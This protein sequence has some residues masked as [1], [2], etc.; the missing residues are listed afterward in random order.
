MKRTSLERLRLMKSEKTP[1][2]CLT[3]YDFSF[4][5]L[6]DGA[7]VDVVLVGDSLGMVV[8]G[9]STTLPVTLDDIIY[10]TSCVARGC[11][12]SLVVA[13]M[14]FGSYESS[15]EKAFESAARILGE[16]GAHMVKIEGG[17]LVRD[18]ISFLADRGIPVCGHLGLMPQ[19]VNM[20]SGFR[21]QG[22]EEAVA[23]QLLKDANSLD[24]AG[25]SL[26][27][28]EAIPANLAETV[29]Y[30]V[31]SPTIGIGA[32]SGTDGQVLILYDLLG[33]YPHKSPS[34][35]KNFMN[36]AKSIADAIGIYADDVRHR[37]FPAPE[38]SF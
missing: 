13:D 34:F 5:S 30:S 4:G 31:E 14:P 18:T 26:L 1:I 11:E 19:S 23:K 29:T 2:V 20:L 28:L 24:K 21:V 9:H 22:R 10:H 33:I 3:A 8:Q 7:G 15:R 12:K 17:E 16:A 36:D 25:L 6:L 38:H 37:R 27:V 32:G 35:S